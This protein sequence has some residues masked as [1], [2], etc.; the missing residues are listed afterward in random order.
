MVHSHSREIACPLFHVSCLQTVIRTVIH[1]THMMAV[2][3]MDLPSWIGS[4]C[5]YD[6]TYNEVKE[7]GEC[8]PENGNK[9]T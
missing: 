6:L 8:Q 1:D 7:C 9:L 2:P 4:S 5:T 3:E